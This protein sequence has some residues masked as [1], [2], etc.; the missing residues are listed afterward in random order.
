MWTL[1][2]I[3]HNRWCSKTTMYL[4]LQSAWSCFHEAV[5]FVSSFCFT[6]T[7]THTWQSHV[8]A[9][10]LLSCLCCRNSAYFRVRIWR[11]IR[12]GSRL[13][14][15]F[16]NSKIKS[17]AC[18]WGMLYRTV[19]YEYGW[20]GLWKGTQKETLKSLFTKQH[21]VVRVLYLVIFI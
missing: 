3:H 13:L 18:D 8:F 21:V 11:H 9:D 17:N 6:P 20:I 12:I 4:L 1:G 7:N 14:H 10:Q 2:P 16:C 19:R 15:C 5:D